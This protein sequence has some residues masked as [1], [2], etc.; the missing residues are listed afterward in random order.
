[1]GADDGCA[2]P[3]WLGWRSAQAAALVI[4]LAQCGHGQVMSQHDFRL[5][6]LFPIFQSDGTLDNAGVQ[7]LHGAL[8]A[9]RELNDKGDGLYDE[10]LPDVE[11]KLT[12]HDTMRDPAQGFRGA[13]QL[14]Q[15][16][17]ANSGVHAYLG[18]A[19]SGVT[20][21]VSLL[22]TELGMPQISY[23]STAADLSD[24]ERY[25]LL[26]RTPMSDA[27]QANAMADVVA[28]FGWDTVATI[29]ST[30]YYG[31][32][33]MKA[34]R[35]AALVLG[36]DVGV[37][38][39]F[40]PGSQ[41]Q[42][43]TALQDIKTSGLRIVV[44]FCEHGDAFE[45]LRQAHTVELAGNSSDVQWIL[46]DSVASNFHPPPD[47]DPDALSG[48]LSFLPSHPVTP[49]TIGFVERF[50]AQ[51]NA[52]TLAADA[53]EAPPLTA[54]CSNLLD[55]GRGVPL[56][57]VAYADG[58]DFRCVGLNFSTFGG[59]EDNINS[60]APMAYDAVLTLAYGLHALVGRNGVTERD[61]MLAEL[62]A[63]GTISADPSGERRKDLG[64]Q[65]FDSMINV[66]FEGAT[67]PV[68]FNQ[69]QTALDAEGR[70]QADSYRGDRTGLGGYK[71]WQYPVRS[72]AL[73][74]QE[75]GNW[76]AIGNRVLVSNRITWA[77]GDGLRP[78][79]RN[80][81]ID[82]T[83]CS[84]W[85]GDARPWCDT[86]T[87]RCAATPTHACVSTL[88][89][90][91]TNLTSYMPLERPERGWPPA[92]AAGMCERFLPPESDVCCRP[93]DE[94]ATDWLLATFQNFERL[95]GQCDNCL[96]NMRRWAC[97]QICDERNVR[98][99][100]LAVLDGDTSTV[101][102]TAVTGQVCNNYCDTLYLSCKTVEWKD[103]IEFI[104]SGSAHDWTAVDESVDDES[105]DVVDRSA[106]AERFCADVLDV[107][108]LPMQ[109]SAGPAVSCQSMPDPH[110]DP[111]VVYFHESRIC[112][113]TSGQTEVFCLSSNAHSEL[114]LIATMLCGTLVLAAVI[115]EF[116]HGLH[117]K[118]RDLL[119]NASVTLVLSVI[120]GVVIEF[121]VSP[122]EQEHSGT[123]HAADFAQFNK[124]TFS[125]LLLPIII[126][127]SAFNMEHTGMLFF[128]LRLWRIMFFAFFGTLIAL[129]FTGGLILFLDGHIGFFRDP[130]S[131]SEAMMFGSLIS[132]VD[133][134]STLATFQSLGVE[135]RIYALI[136][137][138]AILNDAVAIVAFKVF[139]TIAEG[140]SLTDAVYQTAYISL[141]SVA[142][143][144][145]LGLSITLVFKFH[146]TG[147]PGSSKQGLASKAMSWNHKRKSRRNVATSDNDQTGGPKTGG[148]TNPAID[149]KSSESTGP[150]EHIHHGETEPHSQEEIHH[151]AMHDAMIFFFASLCCYYVAEMLHCSGIITALVAGL[152]CNRYAIENL[153]IEARQYSR[154]TLT[155]LSE[156]CDEL[157]M[158]SIG[159]SF[160]TYLRVFP[161][162]FS[163]VA[164][165][166]VLLSRGI[167][168]FPLTALWNACVERKAKKAKQQNRLYFK[169]EALVPLQHSM[170]MLAGGL[171]GAVALALVMAMPSS[172]FEVF[173]SATLFIIMFTNVVL[174]GATTSVIAALG[175]HSKMAGNM[176]AE[177]TEFTLNEERTVLKWYDL[178]RRWLPFLRL[179]IDL[180]QRDREL[181]KRRLQLA[182]A[183]AHDTWR[184]LTHQVVESK[185][186]A[187]SDASG[188]RELDFDNT[189]EAEQPPTVGV[190][191]EHETQPQPEVQPQPEPQPE[192]DLDS[193]AA[194]AE[195][196][197]A[198]AMDLL[199]PMNENSTDNPI[200]GGSKF[201]EL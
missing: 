132:A 100:P 139:S 38:Q 74:L 11:V 75:V 121:V 119:P 158:A 6:A 49:G 94:A 176:T 174:G 171:R 33:G 73:V 172:K 50:L 197:S 77:T 131:M 90:N 79:S 183:S 124:E 80:C 146:G 34:F 23:S 91:P 8:L 17:F 143:G 188:N 14:A 42:M 92:T 40:H 149:D 83:L 136:Y 57:H 81:G 41:V 32:S 47:L 179:D 29:A 22:S 154:S 157:I 63:A 5:G 104:Y 160:V 155:I 134:V 71:I 186:S 44:A 96:D 70:I 97:Q 95:F 112:T 152:I 153:S 10:V 2:P 18:A 66:T 82:G 166:L 13:M 142:I 162:L 85:F 147:P 120:L 1:M 192:P 60:Y 148:S 117:G 69:G 169:E 88:A 24:A 19:S 99:Q 54:E 25:P 194:E 193:S 114:G 129:L 30:S 68:R 163:V 45:L 151:L 107:D 78:E 190:G 191:V 98:F 16:P 137:G 84:R 196:R 200:V 39:N 127:S 180:E 65:L 175:V 187:R 182:A 43:Q 106:P 123:H 159:V 36:I 101:V 165:V 140:F 53:Q 72:D 128:T 184:D 199:M 164:T 108:V 102:D 138:E 93:K 116:L 48:L 3:R 109:C 135:P 126:F 122:Y 64:Q 27:H 201:D 61:T 133:P 118:F 20:K 31:Q 62:D 161:A 26:M 113:P 189:R 12:L 181:L 150:D 87:S 86:N 130:I 89:V 178:E 110:A 9:I 15:R 105:D 195:A 35:D 125:F 144:F 52:G 141:G 46:P 170:M 21:Q 103:S 67:G 28:H 168:V 156:L 4:G 58:Q 76:T 198:A 111:G 115:G 185:G 173:A 167:S 55:D 37:A 7:R 51:Q 59:N 145:G 177:D 56:L